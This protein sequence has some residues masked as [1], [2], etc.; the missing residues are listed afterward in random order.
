MKR[1]LAEKK[2]KRKL[3]SNSKILLFLDLPSFHLSLS[4]SLSSPSR[5]LGMFLP[6][7]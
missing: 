3:S 4:L 1:Y 7:R 2:T 6:S 5:Y